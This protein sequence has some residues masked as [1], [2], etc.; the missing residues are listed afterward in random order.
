MYGRLG[1]WQRC[2]TPEAVLRYAPAVPVVH[3]RGCLWR[4]G[5]VRPG[6]GA[7]TPPSSAA[8]TSKPAR[9]LFPLARNLREGVRPRWST[10]RAG[11]EGA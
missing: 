9:T 11:R 4:Q 3:D 5:R 8:V 10:L 6:V 7:R 2:R 1:P